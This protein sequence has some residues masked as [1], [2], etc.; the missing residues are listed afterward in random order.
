LCAWI[1]VDSMQSNPVSI[2]DLQTGPLRPSVVLKNVLEPQMVFIYRRYPKKV[3]EV[4]ST[5]S[6][7]L[8]S[9]LSV[10]LTCGYV[11]AVSMREFGI[12]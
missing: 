6:L 5:A 7:S 2:S 4:A 3:P 12:E 8:S 11:A 10:E 9:G 1:A